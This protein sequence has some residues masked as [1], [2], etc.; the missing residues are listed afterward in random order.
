MLRKLGFFVAAMGLAV[1]GTTAMPSEADAGVYNYAGFD[2]TGCWKYFSGTV[3]SYVNMTF[4]PGTALSNQTSSVR[5][6]FPDVSVKWYDGTYGTGDSLTLPPGW[7][8]PN[9]GPLNNK[10]SSHYVLA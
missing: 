9:L 1:M 10:F 2:Y 5:N 4:C 7:G 3:E 6:T 8:S